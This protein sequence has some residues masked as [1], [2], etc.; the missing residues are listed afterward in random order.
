M[1]QALQHEEL[2]P[3]ESAAREASQE[4]SGRQMNSVATAIANE[5]NQVERPLGQWAGDR[6][7]TG[8]KQ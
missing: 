3:G 1:R 4:I 2:T 6:A 8:G 5:S 7:N